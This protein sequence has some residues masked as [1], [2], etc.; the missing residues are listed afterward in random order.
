MKTPRRGLLSLVCI[1]LGLPPRL[2]AQSGEAYEPAS[3]VADLNRFRD[4]IRDVLPSSAADTSFDRFFAGLVGEAQT[5]RPPVEFFNIV[6]RLVARTRD[7]HAR[8]YA[9]GDLR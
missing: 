3:M 8:A 7:G 5:P 2:H 9:N 6:T 4:A 1:C